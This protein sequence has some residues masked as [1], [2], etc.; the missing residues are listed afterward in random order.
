MT[1]I[2]SDLEQTRDPW[3]CSLA[4]ICSQT[5]YRLCCAV[6]HVLLGAIGNI[7]EKVGIAGRIPA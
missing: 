3:I 7:I 4:C 6:Q 2:G 5:R 1:Q